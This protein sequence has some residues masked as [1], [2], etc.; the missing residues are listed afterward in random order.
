M[1]RA[2]LIGAAA[3]VGAVAL[4]FFLT[5]GLGSSEAPE[6]KTAALLTAE[7]WVAGQPAGEWTPVQVPERL[8]GLLV[9]P[10][11]LTD[12]STAAVNLPAGVIV[13]TSDITDDDTAP[14]TR[15][16][17]VEASPAAGETLIEGHTVLLWAADRGCA[18][19]AG[20]LLSDPDTSPVQIAVPAADA[21]AA[22]ALA[23][24]ELRFPGDT[25]LA[26]LAG[27]LCAP[28]PPN[29]LVVTLPTDLS[30]WFG[31]PPTA[32]DRVMLG[33]VAEGKVCSL[34]ELTLWSGHPGEL[35]AIATSP[36]QAWE[37]QNPESGAWKILPARASTAAW[38]CT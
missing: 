3:I 8:I 37:L 29:A 35:K 4:F 25:Q 6:P 14:G 32:G 33:D 13:R 36:Q 9:A 38:R 12:T 27:A 7:P 30:S 18:Q 16:V 1:S 15:I 24:W 28:V 31:A 23:P 5:G 2:N 22:E 21:A 34:G 10:E 26:D 11:K 19:A 20:T 17:H